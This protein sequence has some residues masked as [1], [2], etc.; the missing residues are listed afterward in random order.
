MSALAECLEAS[1][2]VE[3]PDGRVLAQAPDSDYRP[4]PTAAARRRLPVRAALGDQTRSYAVIRVPESRTGR[5]GAA[6]VGHPP[7]IEPGAWMAPVALGGELAGRLWVVDP[8]ASPA[9]VGPRRAMFGTNFPIEK[10][11]TSMAVLLDAWRTALS[12]LSSD[13]QASV[14]AETARTVYR[15]RPPDGVR[16]Q[17][18]PRSAAD[19]YSPRMFSIMRA[20]CR[21]S[22]A[23]GSLRSMPRSSPTRRSR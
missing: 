9:P 20:S 7:T 21:C 3:D 6:A 18:S 5:P 19:T 15:L 1:V 14:L 12:G 10:I 17:S 13:E 23:C 22:M 11:W 8:R 4:P 16:A 2:T